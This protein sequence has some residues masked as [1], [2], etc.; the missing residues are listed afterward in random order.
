MV[1]E[2]LTLLSPLRDATAE[3]GY[4]ADHIASSV[5]RNGERVPVLREFFDFIW[6]DRKDALRK[7]RWP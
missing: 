3:A 2:V 5:V 7:K 1:W 4:A 6:L